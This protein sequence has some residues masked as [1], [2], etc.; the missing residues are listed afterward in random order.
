MKTYAENFAAKGS[1]KQIII[2][3]L[4]KNHKTE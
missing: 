1:V 2:N 3:Q 4:L